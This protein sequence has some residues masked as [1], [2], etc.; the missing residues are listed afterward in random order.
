[1]GL[2][3]IVAQFFDN[4]RAGFDFIFYVLADEELDAVGIVVSD[5]FLHQT[6]LVVFTTKAKNQNG[7]GVRIVNKAT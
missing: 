6:D 3:R 7:T 5:N 1:M 2:S 4:R